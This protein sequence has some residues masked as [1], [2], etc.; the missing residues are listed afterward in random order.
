LA[1]SI[2]VLCFIFLTKAPNLVTHFVAKAP[3]I[4]FVESTW[5]QIDLRNIISANKPKEKTR[6]S[7]AIQTQISHLQT[8][9]H[10]LS[11]KRDGSHGHFSSNPYKEEM[12]M[13]GDSQ[14]CHVVSAFE[15]ELPRG[16]AP[17]N[18]L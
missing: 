5:K 16:L 11:T 12:A 14:N 15:E 1:I 10:P 6:G 8:L 4:M 17:I 2:K 7:R 3:P 13:E 9:C 18:A